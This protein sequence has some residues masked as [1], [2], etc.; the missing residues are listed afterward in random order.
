LRWSAVW[1]ICKPRGRNFDHATNGDGHGRID[2][3]GHAHGNGGG[4]GETDA[5]RIAASQARYG[6]D[7]EGDTVG[8]QD[9]H[10]THSSAAD[11]DQ[12]EQFGVLR[13]LH[14]GTRGG[15]GAD[16]SWRAGLLEQTRP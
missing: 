14:R 11:R 2:R 8:D 12:V 9:K 16:S 4:D 7:E 3:H 6:A 5:E 10:E 15:S 13:K 1:L